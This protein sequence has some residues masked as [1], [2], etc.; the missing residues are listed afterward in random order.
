MAKRYLE[1]YYYNY[2]DPEVKLQYVNSDVFIKAEL[3]KFVS[4]I[5]NCALLN[6]LFWGVWALQL[7]TPDIYTQEGIFNYDFA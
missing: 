7:L 6:N 5:W 4:E 3:D 1:C 2:M